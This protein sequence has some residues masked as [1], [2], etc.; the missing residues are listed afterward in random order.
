M[1]EKG[2]EACPSSHM[3]DLYATWLQEHLAQQETDTEDDTVLNTHVQQLL[4]DL[5]KRAHATGNSAT[6]LVLY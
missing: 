5:C 1:F 6:F 4:L 3:F 2:L